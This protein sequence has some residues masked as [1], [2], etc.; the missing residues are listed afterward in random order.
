[1]FIPPKNHRKS[2]TVISSIKHYWEK[3]L[4]DRHNDTVVLRT[5]S[6]ARKTYDA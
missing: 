3:L 4:N 1:M 2:G 6:A 5:G